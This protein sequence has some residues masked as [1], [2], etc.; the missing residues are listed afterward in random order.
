[1]T[2]HAEDRGKRMPSPVRTLIAPRTI[3]AELAVALLLVVV[4]CASP[5]SLTNPTATSTVDPLSRIHNVTPGN[6]LLFIRVLFTPA[7][8]FEQAVAIVG[9][10]PYPWDCDAPR[11]PVPPS[12]AEQR[13]AFAASHILYLSYP[14]Q[15]QLIQI[16]SSPQVVSVVGVALFQC[17]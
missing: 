17:P 3:A 16:A 10:N 13:A 7:T 4:A 2:W 9:G 6:S 14:G 15:N 5:S 11:T 8:T 1:M 12:L